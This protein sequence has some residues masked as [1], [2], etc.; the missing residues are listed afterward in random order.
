[1]PVMPSGTS[2][3]SVE[4]LGHSISDFRLRIA[5]WPIGSAIV[6]LASTAEQARVEVK[7]DWRMNPDAFEIRMLGIE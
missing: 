1:M 6:D 4:I 5:D 3:L 2:V 7:I